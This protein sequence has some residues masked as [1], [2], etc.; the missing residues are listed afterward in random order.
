M[1]VKISAM[2]IATE[3]LWVT[4]LRVEHQ[5]NPLGMDAINPRFRWTITATGYHVRQTA[6]RI[7]VES[8][9]EL[10]WDS[11][12]VESEQSLDVPYA[13][14]PLQSRQRYDWKVKVWDNKGRESAWSSGY[15]EMGLLH[16]KDWRARWIEPIQEA[17]VEEDVVTIVDL[18]SGNFAPRTLEDLSSRL[19]P[20]Q[21]VRRTFEVTNRVR[22][23]RLY[24][25]AH[26]IYRVELNGRRVGDAEF[27]PDFTPYHQYL[28]YQ[29]YDVTMLLREGLNAIGVVIADGWYIGRIH[30][31]GHSC[32][33]GNKL[34]VLLQLEVEYENGEQQIVGSDATFK[35]HVG[36]WVYAD[37]FIGEKYD[38]RR[39]QPG[40]SSPDFDDTD[41]L[42]C[43]EVDYPHDHL[44]AQYGPVVRRME[45]LRPLHVHRDSDGSQV[46]DFGQVIAGRIRI[47]L[48]DVAE[49]TEIRIEH[50]EVLD[51]NGQFFI[52]IMGRN[53]HQ[54]DIYI[55]GGRGYE[56]YEPAFTYHGFRYV[57]VKGHP[58]EIQP[59]DIEAVVLYS[60]M[61][62]TGTFR[63]SD[64]RVNQLQS[65]ILWSQKT[66]MLSIPTDC[67]Q[68][69]RAGW[70]GDMQVFA[71]TATFNMD[72]VSFLRRWMTMVRLE[73][74]PD[75]SIP[76]H[77]PTGRFFEVE[78]APLG[79]SSAGW[80]DAVVIIPWVLYQRYGDLRILEENYDAMRRWLHYVRS[81]AETGKTGHK[82]YL[83]NTGFHF[84]DWMIPSVVMGDNSSLSPIDSA[85]VTGELVAT[86]F[87][88][89][90]CR[91]VSDIA[92]LLG[93]A[94]EAEAYRELYVQI[95]KAF[96]QE[97]VDDSGRLYAHFQGT[98]VLALYM[99]M[100]SPAKRPLMVNQLIQL[101][102]RN[103]WRLDTGFMSTPF[104]MD[105]LCNAGRQDVA[106]KLFWQEECPSWL[107]EV[108]HGA[109]T[110]WER[111]D[112]ISPD[113]VVRPVSYNHF[114]LGCV[115]DWM[116]RRI[117]GLRPLAP[118]FKQFIV[119]PD[120]ECGLEYVIL[121][122]VTPYGRVFIHWQRESD[123]LF[124]N[125]CVPV[126]TC[127][128]VRVRAKTLQMSRDL[129]SVA[130]SKRVNSDRWE[131]ELGSGEYEM[132]AELPQGVACKAAAK[133]GQVTAARA[134]SPV[135]RCER[136]T[137]TEAPSEGREG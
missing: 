106:Y 49:G 12:R 6:Y 131:V 119:E 71:P 104:L 93:H 56:V 31:A 61:N 54:T 118:G 89:Y 26:G 46:V 50:S 66:N 38:A 72:V 136:E 44:R 65:N 94:E 116:Y 47:R 133:R 5:R 117:G 40:W 28:Q 22:R 52:N 107:Y 95:R 85:K 53:K 137:M 10:V 82:R 41:W 96:E 45:R 113:G 39:E 100:V 13:G 24:V 115:G 92:D 35:C 126:N 86:C 110:I 43:Q 79:T 67:P 14:P 109:T 80:G 101:I 87:Y 17:A 88:A 134:P 19:R 60:D 120:I 23:A 2:P 83:W 51:A 48:K 29:T 73:Q 58:K 129:Q 25:T 135:A 9:G 37:L 122:H 130:L 3:G 11:G 123:K 75:G 76:N 1:E 30:F 81:Q 33:Y 132:V 42:P 125:L 62:I 70:T 74:R 102:E 7:L 112:A 63:C 57:R 77:V 15:W 59:E 90:S 98:Y 111:W 97:Y 4:D 36:P 105:V 27:S 34:G 114:A 121:S 108:N 16:S 20:P 55:A 91:I 84:G 18:V 69:E 78:S 128:I 127:A 124:L 99:D 32:Q 64:D 8:N 68:R 103:R 21:M